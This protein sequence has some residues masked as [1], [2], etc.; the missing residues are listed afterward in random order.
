M[1][2]KMLVSIFL[3]SILLT[4][5][6]SL[7]MAQAEKVNLE[8]Q[9]TIVNEAT[10][11]L[12]IQAADLEVFVINF[13][14]DFAFTFTQDDLGTLVHV[15]GE[16]QEDGSIL[17]T[18]VKPVDE[19]ENE[20][21][22]TGKEDSAYCSGEKETAHPVIIILANRFDKDV[23]ELMAYFCDGFGIGQIFLALQTEKISGVAYGDL[24]ASRADG[25]GWGQIW[26]DLGYHGK[27]KDDAGTPPGQAKDKDKDT[28]KTPPGQDTD[29][30]KDKTPPGQ[31]KDKDKDKPPKDK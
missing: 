8:G 20:S 13:A 17:A 28:D 24:L 4:V 12:T 30:D 19:G 21:D 14:P 18:W 29:K 9:I 7:G 16:Y 5:S 27:P 6:F 31:A 3:V 15:K 10:P 2:R 26:K 23:D 1:K 22:D 25:Q 11:S